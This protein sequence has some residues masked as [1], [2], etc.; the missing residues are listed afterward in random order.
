MSAP[1]SPLARA[2][3]QIVGPA[4]I[5]AALLGAVARALRGGVGES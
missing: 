4:S 5:G 3:I 2:L 1:F